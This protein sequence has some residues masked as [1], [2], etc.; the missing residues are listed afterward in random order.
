M[1][2]LAFP[3]GLL[4]LGA[5]SSSDLFK[6]TAP[7]DGST[8]AATEDASDVLSTSEEA[9]ADAGGGRDAF[10]EGSADATPVRDA[11]TSEGDSGS[12]EA[13]PPTPTSGCGLPATPG[14]FTRTLDLAGTTRT[15][16]LRIPAGYAP[17]VPRALIFALHGA[18][19]TGPAAIGQSIS[20]RGIPA[21]LVGPTAAGTYWGSSS[22]TAFID[23]LIPLLEGEF[24]IDKN[25]VFATGYSSGGFMAATLACTRGNVFKGIGVLAGGGG[26]NC[27]NK[28]PMW[29]LHNTDD[30]TV[31]IA[32]GTSL[33]DAWVRINQCASTTTPTTPTPCVSYNGCAQGYPVV[34]CNPATGGHR[35]SINWV[36][37]VSEFFSSL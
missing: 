8:G 14:V 36:T 10:R 25:Q 37:G 23:A 21:V 11:A 24:C 4:A 16:G 31:P 1:R 32:N 9:R 27:P 34:W 7:E 30:P 19:A 6:T 15:Y 5:C 22:D 33:R 29:I 20:V 13:G 3:F 2:Y 17:N 35:P 12:H 18:G 26:G 28:V